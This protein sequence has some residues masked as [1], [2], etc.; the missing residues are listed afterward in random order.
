MKRRFY[1]MNPWQKFLDS[2]W[3]WADSA[4]RNIIEPIVEFLIVAA[5]VLVVAAVCDRR[6]I[7]ANSRPS[8]LT[9]RRYRAFDL[10]PSFAAPICRANSS[11]RNP[12]KAEA[13]RRRE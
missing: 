12:M 2:V 5:A 9:E 13:W 3:K 11:R 1:G 4:G 7:H 6:G 8:A 10:Q